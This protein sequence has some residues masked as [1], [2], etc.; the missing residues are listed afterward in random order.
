MQ[1]VREGGSESQPAG[2]SRIAWWGWVGITLAA[3]QIAL[4]VVTQIVPM[5][6]RSWRLRDAPALER[7]ARLAY[8]N[9]FSDYVLFLRRTIPDDAL[10]VIP[11][12]RADPVLSEMSFMQYFLFPRRLTNCAEE[13]EW[14]GCVA[15]FG[16]AK[17]YV[18]AV[19][20]F[21][22]V[23]GLEDSKTYIPFD[24]TRGVWVPTVSPGGE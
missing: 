13:S 17:T 9:D 5:L 3:T 6:S 23:L 16:G 11:W 14:A 8:G 21:P 7:S 19:K 4:L 12:S 2:D 1:P 24:E 20:T 15:N 22:P 18:L 10:V